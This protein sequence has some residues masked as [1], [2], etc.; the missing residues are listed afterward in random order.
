MNIVNMKK[1][2]GEIPK[3]ILIFVGTIVL[4]ITIISVVV[5]AIFG[6]SPPPE[7]IIEEVRVPIYELAVG[8]IKFKL[9]KAEILDSELKASESCYPDQINKDI[10]TKEKFVKVIISARNIGTDNID[11]GWNIEHLTDKAGRNFYPVTKA[12]FWLSEDESQCS[13]LL[14][15]GFTPTLCSKIYEVAK[16]SEELRINVSNKQKDVKGIKFLIDLGF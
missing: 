10:F 7:P 9:I 5:F 13:A 12:Q 8:D 4:V 6:E 1:S 2:S 14:K 15:P 11:S 3:E 16:I